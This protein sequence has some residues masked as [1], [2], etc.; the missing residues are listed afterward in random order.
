MAIQST[1]TLGHQFFN[2]SKQFI[3]GNYLQKYNGPVVT[4]G[5]MSLKEKLLSYKPTVDWKKIEKA[6]FF[7]LKAHRYQMR[8]SGEHYFGHLWEVANMLVDMRLDV[9]SIVAGLLHD[10]VEDTPTTLETIA[11]IFGSDVARLVDGLTKLSK[12]KWQTDLHQQNENFRK[13]IL[14][15]IGDVRVLFIKLADRLHN[16]RT[17]GHIQSPKKRERIAQ[18]TL[19]I[20]APLAKRLGLEYMRQML[21]DLCFRE[22]H[23]Q[24]YE[25]LQLKIDYTN[26]TN[27]KIFETILNDLYKA[28]KNVGMEVFIGGRQKT[29]FSIWSKMENKKVEF[30][31]ITDIMAFRILVDD[32][33]ACYRAL[34]IIHEAFV[35]IPNRFKDYIST[36]KENGYQSLHTNIVGPLGYHIEIQIRTFAMNHVG[37]WGAAAHWAYKDRQAIFSH[38]PYEKLSDVL[39]Q[40]LDTPSNSTQLSDQIKMEIFT[41][42]IFCFSPKMVVVEL[43]KG[44]SC[45]DFAYAIHSRVGN[46]A[47]AARVNG[48]VVPLQ[49]RLANG[50]Q[51]EIMTAKYCT[52]SSSWEPYIVTS[53]ARSCLK[54]YHHHDNEKRKNKEIGRL[55]IRYVCERNPSFSS[56]ELL[57]SVCK[58]NAINAH[59]VL[60]LIGEGSLGLQTILKNYQDQDSDITKVL[61]RKPPTTFAINQKLPSHP[62]HG[63]PAG[64]PYRLGLC[65]HPIPGERIF[66]I[67]SVSEVVCIHR[68]I[69]SSLINHSPEHILSLSWLEVHQASHLF[70][71][72]L[73]LVFEHSRDCLFM[74]YKFF[75]KAGAEVSNIRTIRRYGCFWDIV[76]EVGVRGVQHLNET[77]LT[78]SGYPSLSTIERI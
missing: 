57:E 52:V 60:S 1:T 17:L 26:E 2:H 58:K 21:E 77:F 22:L 75:Y 43:P 67:I 35:A 59:D 11:Q 50:D 54:R 49:T 14:A 55:L 27:T 39:K 64:T 10:V 38:E 62:I 47:S 32:R 9:A 48:R 45:I 72:K 78:L 44:S 61:T 12:L 53:K 56:Q 23:P 19:Q 33:M 25:S 51:V 34:G 15:M 31:Q 40:I 46:Y 5:L 6:F 37:E 29:P 70:T 74:I 36:P 13:F 69:C 65:C 4:D 3:G 16:M 76:L 42:R 28:L 20:Y 63:M 71:V 7:A 24:T 68:A 8:A 41:D 30:G 66:G 73:H 18:E